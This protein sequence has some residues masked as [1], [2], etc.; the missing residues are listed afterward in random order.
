ML[1]QIQQKHNLILQTFTG[2]T[3][4]RSIMKYPNTKKQP[5]TWSLKVS[6][7]NVVHDIR[8]TVPCLRFRVSAVVQRCV[9]FRIRSFPIKILSYNPLPRFCPYFGRMIQ[10]G[11]SL[12]CRVDNSM[13]RLDKG[14]WTGKSHQVRSRCRNRR[15]F[16]GSGLCD[17]PQ[18]VIHIDDSAWIVKT[19]PQRQRI[20]GYQPRINKP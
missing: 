14:S 3:L 8:N 13:I 16:L 15:C 19:S 4:L 6:G 5:K 18:R 7:F 9:M 11:W 20:L 1:W 12:L 2:R 17:L 10:K